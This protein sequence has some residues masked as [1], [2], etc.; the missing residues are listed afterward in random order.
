MLNSES[1][2][3]HSR[4]HFDPE[5]L[6]G[7]FDALQQDPPYAGLAGL[8]RSPLRGDE[9]NNDRSPELLA[10]LFLFY[11]FPENMLSFSGR[12]IFA[13][14]VILS[15]GLQRPLNCSAV[16]GVPADL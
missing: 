13:G 1:W 2:L 11:Q 4:P 12:V 9:T 16:S 3:F 6:A 14:F 8:G 10:L 7:G 15:D 5:G